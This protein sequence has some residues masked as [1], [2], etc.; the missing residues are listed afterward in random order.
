[1]TKEAFLFPGQ[2][3]QSKNMAVN[4]L[5]HKNSNIRLIA[6]RTFEESAGIT[7]IN[8]IDI[9]KNGQ[10]NDLN[11]PGITEP[12]VFTTSMAAYRTL[13]YLEHKPD[14]VAGHSLGEFAALVAARALTFSQAVSLVKA[15]GEYMDEAGKQ[16]PGGMVAILGLPLERVEEICL[17]TGAEVANIN[18]SDQI[19]VAGADK[20]ISDVLAQVSSPAKAIKLRVSIASHC[21]L[22]EPAR[23]KMEKLLDQELI[24]MPHIPF[25]QNVTGDMELSSNGIRNGL[26]N[27]IASRV[28]WKKTIENMVGYGAERFID[29]GPRQVMAGLA[30]KN[31]PEAK[32]LTLQDILN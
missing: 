26:V 17:Q 27:Q 7:G 25:F 14:I 16:N 20:S 11:I 1:M 6:E 3:T 29:V 24:L 22:M 9:F 31:A 19:V 4:L 18:S 21:S 2:G 10:E 15:R 32:I 28:L 12:A 13:L 5:E 8:L 30:R 23:E